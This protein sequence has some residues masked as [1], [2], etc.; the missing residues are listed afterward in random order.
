MRARVREFV[1]RE[2]EG[3]ESDSSVSRV[4]K[5]GEVHVLLLAQQIQ[6]PAHR[7]STSDRRTCQIGAGANDQPGERRLPLSLFPPKKT[8]TCVCGREEKPRS[9][10]IGGAH[11]RTF[12]TLHLRVSLAL[13]G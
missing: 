12:V 6:Y 9:V 13:S 10:C 2:E 11:A 4:A 7:P 1:R 8:N 3:G 5:S